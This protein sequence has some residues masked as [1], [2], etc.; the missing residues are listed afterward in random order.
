MPRRKGLQA[1]TRNQPQWEG[2]GAYYPSGG[3]RLFNFRRIV[4][5]RS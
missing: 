5:L 4:M 2:N 1:V 3:S